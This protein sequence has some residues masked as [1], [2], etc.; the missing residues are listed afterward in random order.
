MR[1]EDLQV[2]RTQGTAVER[3]RQLG[4]AGRDALKAYLALTERSLDLFATP[5]G[6]A[7]RANLLDCFYR[8]DAPM[9]LQEAFCQAAGVPAETLIERAA[10]FSAGK[11]KLDTECSGVVL[12]RGG[13]VVLGQNLDTGT[14]CREANLLEIGHDPG[15]RGYAR[16]CW[17]D[18]LSYMHGVN[19]HGVAT[20]GA[21]G[22][23]GDPM[24]DGKGLAVLLSRW[25]YFYC[26]ATPAGVAD[27]VMRHRI[28]GKGSNHVWASASGDIVGTEQGGG[29]AAVYQPREDWCAVTGYRPHIRGEGL[30]ENPPEKAAA[31]LARWR[32]LNAL[33]EDATRTDGDLVEQM[34]RIL[35]DHETVD[36]HPAS[37]PC[38]HGDD[39]TGSTQFSFIYDLT[40]CTVHY[41]GQP[42]TNQWQQVAL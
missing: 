10:A 34:K 4:E 12:K 11:S 14:E 27:V 1:T 21:S 17:P 24:G 2:M 6:Q 26:C 36:G 41:C 23:P 19:I 40:R 30:G 37:A 32:R 29:A 7:L 35:T 42:C 9:E 13:E 16:F 5:R 20:G 3:A 38:R 8:L 18:A 15:G 31:E 39:S 28:A 33:A 25:Q 22:P